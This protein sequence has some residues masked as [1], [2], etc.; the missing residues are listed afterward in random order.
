M[1]KGV[2]V[3][4][5]RDMCGVTCCSVVESSSIG[6]LMKSLL[7]CEITGWVPAFKYKVDFDFV[8]DDGGVK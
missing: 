1:C 2:G 5:E 4:E 6:G 3:G 8:G 7:A